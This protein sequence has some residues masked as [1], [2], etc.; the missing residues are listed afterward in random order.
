MPDFPAL[1]DRFAAA[2]V[3]DDGQGLAALFTEDGTY[4]DGFFG[5]H[6]GRPAIAAMLRRF[7]DT[8]RDYRWD[9]SDPLT[10]GRTAYARWRFSYASRLPGCEGKPVMFEGISR[11]LFRGDLIAHYAEAFDRGVALVQLAMPSDRIAR[12]LEKAAAEQNAT[13]EARAHLDR[14]K[15]G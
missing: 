15:T 11:F 9:W 3:T 10:D 1:L 12:I 13:R 8:G 7:H 2:I 4:D 6:T 14:F 5:A